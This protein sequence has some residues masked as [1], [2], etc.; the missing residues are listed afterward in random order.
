MLK[1]WFR[2]KHILYHY[3]H[4]RMIFLTGR[5][6]VPTP[7]ISKGNYAN[8]STSRSLI[9]PFNFSDIIAFSVNLRTKCVFLVMLRPPLP[10][11]THLY[12]LVSTPPPPLGAYVI[13]GRPQT[14]TFHV[15][16]PKDPL[17]SPLLGIYFTF[18]FKSKGLKGDLFVIFT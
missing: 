5:K 13:N 1:N 14:F 3:I 8:Q 15:N 16:M 4:E 2:S 10:P 9:N 7:V 12:A 18:A 6:I 17:S 11:C